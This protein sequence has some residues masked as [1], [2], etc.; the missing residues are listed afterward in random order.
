MPLE[1]R[2]RNEVGTRQESFAF[3]AAPVLLET[4]AFH[5]L[6][7]RERLAAGSLVHALWGHSPVSPAG[8]LWNSLDSGQCV[9]SIPHLALSPTELVSTNTP[10]RI[11]SQRPFIDGRHTRHMM[12]KS[13]KQNCPHN[14]SQPYRPPWPVTVPITGHGGL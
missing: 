2:P 3:R 7:S 14:I 5:P 6:R 9:Y 12:R 10:P 4:V 1:S 13:K 11:S 8:M